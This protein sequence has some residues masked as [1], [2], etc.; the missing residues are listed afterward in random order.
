MFDP[1]S[2]QALAISDLFV[3]TLLI[4]AGIL[5]L[6]TGL[7]LYIAFR[8]RYKPGMGE[9]PQNFGHTPLEIGWT[10]GPVL[11]LAVLLVLTVIGMAQS[12]PEVKAQQQPDLT[13]TAH[14]WWWEI[15]YTQSGI[16]TANEVR[17]PVGRRMLVRLDSADVVHDLWIPELARKMD[18]TPGHPTTIW[19]Q[20][21]KPG[22][23][24][25]AC[26][27]YCGVQHAKMGI[28]AIAQPQAEFDAW[29]RQQ[30]QVPAQPTSGSAAR[31]LQEFK[32]ETCISCHA[33]NGVATTP[34]AGPDL[35]HIA[36]RRTLA[37]GVLENTPFNLGRWLQNPQAIKPGSY[38]PNVQL[39]KEEVQTLVDYMETLK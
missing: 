27:E 5:L 13:V 17:L 28:L 24:P 23:Y 37:A 6:V 15:R 34:H 9:P 29:V 26:A 4:A 18:M 25:G 8:Y 22:V 39:T 33:I 11:I 38:M 7:V 16:V 10:A 35:T 1:K 14:Q 36:S 3:I 30:T 31:G 2:P 20:A 21:D 32:E 19:L 12:D